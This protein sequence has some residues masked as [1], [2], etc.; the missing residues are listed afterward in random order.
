VARFADHAAVLCEQVSK[1]GP[2]PEVVLAAT[3][4]WYWAVDDCR[5]PVPRCIRRIRW[6]DD[7]HLPAGEE[8]AC[9]MICGGDA[10]RA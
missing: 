8:R 3:Y 9:Q 2:A 4:G 1:A 5:L 7:V 6:G 10:V